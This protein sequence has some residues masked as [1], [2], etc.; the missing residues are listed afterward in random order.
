MGSRTS[1][2]AATFAAAAVVAAC[3]QSGS[4]GASPTG[5]RLAVI[6]TP[7]AS[8]SAGPSLGSMP[9]TPSASPSPTAVPSPPPRATPRTTP[10]PEPTT[11]AWTDEESFLSASLRSDVALE[12]RPRRSDLPARAIAGIE[13][14]PDVAF[15]DRVGA[16]LFASPDDMLDTYL[17]RMAEHGITPEV[18]NCYGGVSGDQS[19][20]ASFGPN[21]GKPW[22]RAGCFLDENDDANVRVTC[23]NAVYIGVLGV[24]S[25]LRAIFSWAMQ[26]P[27]ELE[28]G[29]RYGLQPGICYGPDTY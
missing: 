10:R 2:I 21:E 5:S 4:A 12:C 19:W 17:E 15:V 25:D 11:T 1:I 29:S 6:A 28:I 22:G 14:R 7:T 20:A 26:Y 13:C 9:A 18:G 16:Y 24:N 8:S 3:G 27:E 23:D